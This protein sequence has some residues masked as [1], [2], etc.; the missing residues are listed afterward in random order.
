MQLIYLDQR[1]KNKIPVI[2][3]IQTE[4]EAEERETEI[5]SGSYPVTVLCTRGSVSGKSVACPLN[6]SSKGTV[7]GLKGPS[8]VV[9]ISPFAGTI[10][11][12]IKKANPIKFNKFKAIFR[13]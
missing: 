4:S 6:L 10:P 8:S 5:C 3:E 2:Q 7:T 1:N 13:A 11:N 9:G 12:T